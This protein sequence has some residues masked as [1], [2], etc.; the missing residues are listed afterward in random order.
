METM[1]TEA[2]VHLVEVSVHHILWK[3]GL[4]PEAAFAQRQ[5]FGVPVRA[6]VHPKVV[7]YVTEAMRSLKLMLDNPKAQAHVQGF[8]VAIMNSNEEAVKELYSFRFN[9]KVNQNRLLRDNAAG[10]SGSTALASME[11]APLD[12][13]IKELFRTCLLK[14][15]HKM[16]DIPIKTE[17]KEQSK[18]TFNFRIVTS[19]EGSTFL[20]QENPETDWIFVEPK[21]MENFSASIM[22]VHNTNDPVPQKLFIEIT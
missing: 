22:P 1:T 11:L 15:S 19:V 9:A 7:A 2:L 21:K 12:P 13:M 16:N 5:V 18:R 20:R 17:K 14:L 6:A 8:D 3:R 10:A 4:Y